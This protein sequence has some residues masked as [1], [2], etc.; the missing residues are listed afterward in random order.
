MGSDNLL[1]PKWPVA[2]LL[3]IRWDAGVSEGTDGIWQNA[4]EGG[5][6]CCFDSIVYITIIQLGKCSMTLQILTGTWYWLFL[7]RKVLLC[8]WLC[9]SCQCINDALT[10]GFHT[11]FS[12]FRPSRC[13]QIACYR[14]LGFVKLTAPLLILRHYLPYHL[15]LFLLSGILL[16]TLYSLMLFR[17]VAVAGLQLHLALA[18]Y[19][20]VLPFYP[21]LRPMAL[22]VENLM[23][24]SRSVLLF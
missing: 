8:Y 17:N 21:I 10:R 7:Q 18:T 11:D 24:F 3:G 2:S 9:T 16:A 19:F 5:S 15:T 1:G 20:R 23:R 22:C 12:S 4:V 14:L 13:D 6:L